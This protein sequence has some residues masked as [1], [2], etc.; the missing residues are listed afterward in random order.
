MR[1]LQGTVCVF[2]TRSIKLTDRWMPSHLLEAGETPPG[3]VSRTDILANE[4]ADKHASK[5]A[6][7]HQ[8]S[9]NVATSLNYFYYYYSGRRIQKRLA[10]I[11]TCLPNHNNLKFGNL[12]VRKFKIL[13]IGN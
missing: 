3:G 4:L 5:A 8:I 11:I 13:K 12:K 7:Q 1:L 9:L 10:E 2:Q 6:K